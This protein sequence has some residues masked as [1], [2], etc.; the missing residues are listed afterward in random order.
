MLKKALKMMNKLFKQYKSVFVAALIVSALIGNV[1]LVFKS[2]KLSSGQTKELK[3]G[4]MEVQQRGA[5]YS[6][7]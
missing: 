7:P 3:K 1:W 5:F 2:P 4:T 6:I